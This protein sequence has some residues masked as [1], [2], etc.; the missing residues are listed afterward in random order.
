MASY[1]SW[2][3]ETDAPLD[4]FRYWFLRVLRSSGWTVGEADVYDHDV[5]GPSGA[6]Y[7]H[8]R[9][10]EDG[11]RLDAKIRAGLLRG[12]ADGVAGDL[13]EAG[14]RSQTRI[15]TDDG[16]GPGEGPVEANG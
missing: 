13:L 2:V 6:A 4:V 15:R 9:Y 12:S 16:A 1:R 14:R 10:H 7:L 11:V 3:F 8:L 5:R